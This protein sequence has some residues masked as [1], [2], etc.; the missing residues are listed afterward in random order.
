MPSQRKVD[1]ETRKSSGKSVIPTSVS[2]TTCDTRTSKIFF[3]HDRKHLDIRTLFCCCASN[4]S[5]DVPARSKSPKKRTLRSWRKST[6]TS[7]I[8]S[9]TCAW[10]FSSRTPSSCVCNAITSLS[11]KRRPFP[12]PRDNRNQT[13]YTDSGLHITDQTRLTNREVWSPKV[14]LGCKK[15]CT[16]MDLATCA[17]DKRRPFCRLL[18][19]KHPLLQKLPNLREHG[20]TQVPCR[21]IMDLVLFTHCIAKGH[22]SACAA[23]KGTRVDFHFNTPAQAVKASPLNETQA[24]L[25]PSLFFDGERMKGGDSS[26]CKR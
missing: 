22:P 10:L 11:K 16:R 7:R 18:H 19:G 5:R 8:S 9:A 12:T 4:N 20:K 26:T 21:I 15:K 25:Q 6:M 24:G 13:P 3:V 1:L 23:K 14:P 17:S 2:P